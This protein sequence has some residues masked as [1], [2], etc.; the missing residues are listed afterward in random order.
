MSE[1]EEHLCSLKHK[2]KKSKIG[3]HRQKGADI[4]RGAGPETAAVPDD[5]SRR[6]GSVNAEVG[7]LLTEA[8]Q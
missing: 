7:G 6:Y 1:G 2:Q 5:T 3:G 8:N 4:N